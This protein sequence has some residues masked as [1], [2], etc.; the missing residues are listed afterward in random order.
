VSA[1]GATG[2]R[3][4][5][6]VDVEEHYQV[7]A[8]EDVV[9]RS[10]WTSIPSRVERN[11]EIVLALLEERGVQATFF[12]VGLVAERFPQLMR[13]IV[14]LGHELGS[15]GYDHTRTIQ[16][17]PERFRLDVRR[18]RQVLEDT[19][20]TA[21]GGYRAPTFSF[22]VATPWAHGALA[23]AGYRYSSSVYPVRHDLYGIPDA[24]RRPYRD[25]QSGLLEVPVSTVRFLGHNVPCG[26]GGF[27]RL[28]PYAAT[29][30][31]VRHLNVV[32]STPAIF[33]THPWELDPQQ[34]RPAGLPAKARFRHYLNLTQ[35]EPR[36]RRLLADFRWDRMD[37][38]FAAD[39]A[40]SGPPR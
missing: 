40:V 37:R 16:L 38:I 31:C 33:Y 10:E 18:V 11:T 9:T 27:F 1:R 32:E 25:P 15:H 3:N 30:W 2:M 19:G 6:T 34:P 26:G 29:R 39:G 21:V 5:F 13:R 14:A 23:E 7:A 22:T 24:P 8:F 17:G 28:Y 4:A 35:T 36:L 20:G 12:V